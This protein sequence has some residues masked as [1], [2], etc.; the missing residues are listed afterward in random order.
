MYAGAGLLFPAC[1]DRSTVSRCVCSAQTSLNCAAV[2]VRKKTP[3]IFGEQFQRTGQ[4]L[5]AVWRVSFP[6]IPSPKDL[7]AVPAHLV[8]NTA[9]MDALLHAPSD[10]SAAQFIFLPGITQRGGFHPA[11]VRRQN[12]IFWRKPHESNMGAASAPLHRFRRFFAFVSPGIAPALYISRVYTHYPDSWVGLGAGELTVC[13]SISGCQQVVSLSCAL[14]L[15]AMHRRLFRCVSKVYRL[16][17]RPAF[18]DGCDPASLS[19]LAF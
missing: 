16:A 2:A 13:R 14:S 18:T 19:L 1:L 7:N 9:H 5:S 8:K 17:F 6:F 4:A 3:R 11:F 15:W 10:T 12:P